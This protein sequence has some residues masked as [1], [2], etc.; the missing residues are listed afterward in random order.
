VF[1][2]EKLN[3]AL[4]NPAEVDR[5]MLEESNQPQLDLQKS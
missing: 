3:D 4:N 1:D 5:K 2:V